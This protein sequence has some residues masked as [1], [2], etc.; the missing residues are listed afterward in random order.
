MTD[1]GGHRTDTALKHPDIGGP[2]EEGSRI[3][4]HLIKA[5][6]VPSSG[7]RVVWDKDLTGFG[8]R[9]TAAGAVSFVLR[10]VLNGRERRYTVGKH[11]DLTASAARER[12]TILRGQIAGGVDPMEARRGARDAAT[13]SE[14]C[15]DYLERHARPKKRPRS[16]EG[17]EQLIRLYVKP[18]LGARKVASINR[19]DLDQVHQNLSDHP[20]Q[21]NRLLALLS[22]MLSLAVLWG[23]RADNPAQGIERFQENRRDRWLSADE[24]GRLSTAL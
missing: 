9:I 3:T 18:K 8:V 23:W 19:R 21:A 4:A 20:Y 7:N 16:V 2:S 17:D 15:E 11:P 5:L 10:Y 1:T 12:A 13:L 14:L 24:L 6:A 22:K